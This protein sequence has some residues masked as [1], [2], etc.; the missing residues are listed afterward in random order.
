M[1]CTN[2]KSDEMVKVSNLFFLMT[3]GASCTHIVLKF[4]NYWMKC[5]GPALSVIVN[6]AC[7]VELAMHTTLLYKLC[8]CHSDLIAH[9]S[10][11]SHFPMTDI[12]SSIG[13]KSI[14]ILSLFSEYF[15]H[16][17]FSNWNLLILTDTFLSIFSSNGWFPFH[18]PF[19]Y[20]YTYNPCDFRIPRDDPMK[21]SSGPSL[22]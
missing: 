4:S 7:K 2:K 18:R 22:I 10:Q 19:W 15:L 14:Y 9:L 12:C 5:G 17:F 11:A 6:T 16:F 1:C 3:N 20:H 21:K 13:Y 8:M